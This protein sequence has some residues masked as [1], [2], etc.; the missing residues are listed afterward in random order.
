M[1]GP[2]GNVRVYLACG[3]TDIRGMSADERRTLRQHHARPVLDELKA[4]IEATLS[5]LPQKQRLAEA[6]R[7]ALSRW[8]TD[9]S[10]HCVETSM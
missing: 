9:G 1:I 4:W 10:N 5:T 3:V 2:S 7:Y 6:M 8:A